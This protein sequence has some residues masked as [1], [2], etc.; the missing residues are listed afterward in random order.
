MTTPMR[1]PLRWTTL[2]IR[3]PFAAALLALAVLA[4]AVPLPPDSIWFAPSSMAT[5]FYPHQPL[6]GDPESGPWVAVWTPADILV[7]DPNRVDVNIT[8]VEV[9]PVLVP[10]PATPD[11]DYS[12]ADLA[13]INVTNYSSFYLQ[14][15]GTDITNPTTD[16]VADLTGNA[17]TLT[18]KAPAM[19]AVR[20]K[21]TS[22]VGGGPPDERDYLYTE[23]VKDYFGEDG[24]AD[25]QAPERKGNL[26]DADL[27]VVS[28]EDPN[29]NGFCEAAAGLLKEQGKNVCLAKDLDEAQK[30]IEDRSKAL[31][32]K[33]KVMMVGH[34]R[35]GSI[36]IGTDWLNEQS[37]AVEYPA[38]FQKRIDAFV[39][40]ITF[41]S[42]KTAE[43]DIG[44]KFL[45]DFGN[46][47]GRAAGW[48][49][50][51]TVSSTI[52]VLG[53][54]L[55]HGYFD[56]KAGG[57]QG[58]EYGVQASGAVMSSPSTFKPEGDDVFY[59]GANDGFLY[60][61]TPS[62]GPVPGFPFDTRTLPYDGKPVPIRS[63]PAIYFGNE[64]AASLYFTTVRGQIVSLHTDGTP[65]WVQ[66]PEPTGHDC[67]ST[68]AIT[69]DGDLFVAINTSIGPR[70]WKLNASTG[71]LLGATPPLGLP[72]STSSS[73]AVAGNLVY[74][75]VVPP[76]PGMGSLFV[77]DTNLNVRA[78]GI[79]Q[80]EGVIA[81]PFVNGMFM[82]D[83]TM[84]GNLYKVN[85]VTMNPDMTFGVGGFA[86]I[87]EPMA[88]SL[89][90][91]QRVPGT[92]ELYAGTAEGRVYHVDESGNYFLI[93][94][95][96]WFGEPAPIQGFAFAPSPSN[97]VLAFGAGHW[98]YEMPV[99]CPMC[100]NVLLDSGTGDWGFSTAPTY[101][102]ASRF[103]AIG[104][105]DGY[106]YTFPNE[107]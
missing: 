106:L 105:L 82:Y 21:T 94:D 96:M 85:S 67:S 77:L 11:G 13:A 9:L 93:L 73:I 29:D 86:P 71:A 47:I 8:G 14:Q 39:D 1:H 59:F 48:D 63:R 12:P 61:E 89:Y 23:Y 55:R 100:A 10:N 4:G 49:V 72:M 78:A 65:R 52:S 64:P 74:V 32:R 97:P 58:E 16:Y 91:V 18:F 56:V 80:N 81:P 70:V 31:G 35:P 17:L 88:T 95:T 103:F 92:V 84:S 69:P 3:G 101:G 104:N 43:G 76:H 42:C 54:V 20:V 41:F 7:L 44:R 27:Y 36:K 45:R 24:G 19:Y 83:G 75:G 51:V 107:F 68:P 99:D 37:D 90:A 15:P 50:P 53:I 5:G 28:S 25:E 34:G 46:S 30:C 33:I 60:A 2:A 22:R 40:D 26:P 6:A 79:A 98:F 102:V 66:W 38:A 57:K 62:G 87:G